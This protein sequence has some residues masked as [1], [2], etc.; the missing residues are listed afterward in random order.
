MDAAANRSRPT[1]APTV[2]RWALAAIGAQV[3]FLASWLVAP[4]W[5][6]PRYSVV[7]HSISDMYAVGAPGG[8][9]LVVALTLCGGVTILF[10]LLSLRPALR[11]GGWG[12]SVGAI[13]LAASV[14]GLGDL[15]SPFER[16]ACRIADPGCTA[17]SQLSNAGGTLDGILTTAG[18]LLF[19]AAGFF[20]A[21]AMARLP[22]WQAWAGPARL[23]S[24]AVLVL[25][26]ATAVT[27]PRGVGG[28]FERLTAGLG[29]VGVAVLA[30]GVVASSPD[31][32]TRAGRS[33]RTLS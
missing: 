2:S 16:L 7:A 11:G 8:A 25:L 5:Q 13:C 6:G 28:L 21:G 9:F 10:V 4:L 14:Y 18:L 1:F 22:A 27:N 23:V 20:L 17:T 26:V 24:V 15:L 32:S 31:A 33:A 29:A 12:V 19:V 3:L 30:S